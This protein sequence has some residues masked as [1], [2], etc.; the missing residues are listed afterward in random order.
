MDIT[1]LIRKEVRS[2]QDD[3]NEWSGEIAGQ[4]VSLFAQS[5]TPADFE[6]LRRR[7]YGDFMGNPSV[8]GMILMIMHKAM[9][10]ENEKV[11]KKKSDIK[12][13]E[14][15]S[16]VKIG[17]IF[18]ELFKDDIEEASVL[19]DDEGFADRVEK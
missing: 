4:S 18:G 1:G 16:T 2:T 15:W 13:L 17:E 5:L 19:D 11:F 7:G 6:L 12:I 14:R 9:D 3:L 10:A 8:G